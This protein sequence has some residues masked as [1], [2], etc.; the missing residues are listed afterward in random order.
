METELIEDVKTVFVSGGPP[1]VSYVSRKALESALLC[2]INT[3]RIISVTGQT[4]SGKT[5]LTSSFFKKLNPITV[6]CGDLTIRSTE[7]FWKT[8]H[9]L[10]RTPVS[11]ESS[12]KTNTVEAKAGINLSWKG[13]VQ[14]SGSGDINQQNVTKETV[15]PTPEDYKASVLAHLRK[16]MPKGYLIIDDFHYLEEKIKSDIVHGFKSLIFDGFNLV[17]VAIPHRDDDVVHLSKEMIGRLEKVRVNQWSVEELKEIAIKGFSRYN[18]EISDE[19]LS[20]MADEAYGTPHLMQ[21][22]CLKLSIRKIIDNSFAKGTIIYPSKKELHTIYHQVAESIGTPILSQISQGGREGRRKKYRLKN[23]QQGD[24][25]DLT[26][27]ALCNMEND[28]TKISFARIYEG[29]KNQVSEMPPNQSQITNVLKRFANVATADNAANPIF[30]YD[31]KNH[32]IYIS[33]PFLLFF[34]KWGNFGKER[35]LN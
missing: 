34:L 35:S 3:N 16:N 20:N 28:K 5:V 30:D 4:K 17:L 32:C 27:M 33:N 24:V 2:I 18:I 13:V 19:A 7:D 10:C 6:S 15:S 1:T 29:V 26:I 8:L 23:G 21:D 14:A 11:S 9:S 25:Y 31:E 22:F 12:I